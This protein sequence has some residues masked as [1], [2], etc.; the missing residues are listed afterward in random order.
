MRLSKDTEAEIIIGPLFDAVDGKTP[1]ETLVLG[2]ISAAIYKNS[3]RSEIELTEENFVHV[4]DGFY[5]LSL[6]ESDTDTI[7]IL[8]ITLRDD[9]VFLLVDKDFEIVSASNLDIATMITDRL[10]EVDYYIDQT[11][12]PWQYVFHKAAD[13]ATVYARKDAFDDSG[14]PVTTKTQIVFKLAEPA[15]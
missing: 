10:V 14:E 11:S 4:A 15:R 9:D 8:K 5:K 3:V 2:D 12:T 1:I 13:P 6:L 7:G